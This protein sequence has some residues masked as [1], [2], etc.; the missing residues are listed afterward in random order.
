[1]A[2]MLDD[3]S[4]ITIQG[5]PIV[6]D[7]VSPAVTKY[8]ADKETKELFEDMEQLAVNKTI[9]SKKRMSLLSRF[10]LKRLLVK[11][12]VRIECFGDTFTRGLFF[13]ALRQ[14]RETDDESKKDSDEL[15]LYLSS[16]DDI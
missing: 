13:V 14:P 5:A 1:M 6:P 10:Y 3:M 8:L 2:N 9:L 11:M 15:D 7:E 16:S 4:N 12:G